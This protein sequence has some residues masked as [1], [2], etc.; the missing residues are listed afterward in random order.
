MSLLRNPLLPVGLILV[1]LGLGNWYT[2]HDK[3]IEHEQLLAAVEPVPP[4]QDFDEFPE[5]NAHTNATLLSF[6][7]RGS[8]P[9]ALITAKL[10]FY[11]VVQSGGRILTLTGLFCA[12]A[13]LIRSWY[14]QHVTERGGGASSRS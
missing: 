8:D 2:G 5:L 6:L 1:L 12:A 7:Q 9:S 4:P 3:T 10:D 14:R 13:A 11:K